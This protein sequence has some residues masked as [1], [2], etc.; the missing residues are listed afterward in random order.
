MRKFDCGC[1]RSVRDV[2]FKNG[3]FMCTKCFWQESE[4]P[5]DPIMNLLAAKGLVVTFKTEPVL[6]IKQFSADELDKAAAVT[7]PD[8]SWVRVAG[9]DFWINYTGRTEQLRD[10][11]SAYSVRKEGSCSDKE[12]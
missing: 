7:T 10:Y 1:G 4:G 9:D 12:D 3:E 6:T 8:E 11:I 2:Y 5:Y